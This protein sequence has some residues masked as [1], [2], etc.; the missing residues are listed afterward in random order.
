MA[1]AEGSFKQCFLGTYDEGA[2]SGQACVV[3]F[4]RDRAVFESSFFD[5]EM[6]VV[7]KS[8]ELLSQWN[9]ARFISQKVRLN[10]PEIWVVEAGEC[11][12]Q[13]CLIEPYIEG[14]A[15]F[16]SNSGWTTSDGSS[17]ADLMQALSHY[18]Y[19]NSSGQTLLCDLQGGIYADGAILTDPVIMS[20]TAGRY[21]PADLGREGII[22]F[23]SQ[24]TCGQY[25]R[26]EWT[27]PRER[28]AFFRPTAATTMRHTGPTAPYGAPFLSRG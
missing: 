13:R 26:A 21:G 1:F 16:N 9:G 25:C 27:K 3:K 18:S 12:G 11:T 4:F 24:H 20:G 6:S 5:A 8:L 19:H 7:A 28:V 15:K 22:S 17:W 14:F 2:R 10:E 23:F